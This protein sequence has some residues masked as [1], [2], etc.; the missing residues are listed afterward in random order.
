M[1]GVYND[2]ADVYLG[3]QNWRFKV[4]FLRLWEMFPIDGLA[5]PFSV[6]MVLVDNKT[7]IRK[8]MMQ[9]FRGVVVEGEVYWMHYFG[10]VRNLGSYSTTN[11]EYKLVFH[12]KTDITRCRADNI[13]RV[14]LT[15]STTEEVMMANFHCD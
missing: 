11:H 2:V 9:K 6:E 3:R 4:R 13:L 1:E 14:A 5:K 12:H 8:P 15:P 7:S 10:V